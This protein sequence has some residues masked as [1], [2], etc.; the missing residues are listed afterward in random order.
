MPDPIITSGQDLLDLPDDQI[1]AM[2]TPPT[3][4]EETDEEKAAR[5]AAKLAEQDTA[6]GG[7]GDDSVP[8]SEEPDE[9]EDDA[10]PTQVDD[11][12]KKVDDVDEDEQPPQQTLGKGAE[13]PTVVAKPEG[14]AKPEKAFDFEAAYKTLM[15][16]IKANG[17][18]IE[19]RSPEELIQLAQMGANYTK[20]M[21][22]LQPHRK[23][24]MM[25]ENNGL[26]DE[27]KLSYLIDLEKKNPEAIKKLVKEAGINPLDIDTE[28]ESTYQQGNHRV[29]DAEAVFTTQLEDL[30]STPDGV[31]TIQ[32]INAWDQASKDVLWTNPALMATIHTQ[33]ENGIYGA[34]ATEIERRRMLGIIPAEVPFL[35]AYKAVGDELN[36]SGAFTKLGKPQKQPVATRT[37]AP[38]PTATNSDKANA[39]A[40]SRS[41]PKAAKPFVN[42]LSMSDDQFMKEFKDRL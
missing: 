6:Q 11:K 16:P 22:A 1:S 42:P 15:A 29:S 28:A 10:P 37:A 13:T 35:H 7:E 32:T 12:S 2:S 4:R 40:P 25:L 39:A 41:T 27:G 3:I 19:I 9:P 5:E 31:Q 23:L 33:R 8:G 20:K 24:L 26:L 17:K 34:I 30:K 18:T 14:N 36:A 21:Q 38:K